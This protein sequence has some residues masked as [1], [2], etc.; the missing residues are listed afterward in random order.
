LLASYQ[1]TLAPTGHRT[2]I[3]EHSGR[4]VN[5][6]YD[7][8]YRLKEEAITQTD[9]NEISF[10]YQYDAIGNRVYSIEDGVHTKYTYDANDQL[11]KQGGV[12]YQYDKNGNTIR[13]A[14]E[15]NVLLYSYDF[16]NRL[17]KVI[18]EENGQVT[19]TVTYAYDADG[20]RVQTN[21][22]GQVTQYVVDSND[23]LSQVVAELDKDNQ[24]KVAY[25]YGDDLVSQ[26]RGNEIAYYHNKKGPGSNYI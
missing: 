18:T 1:Y 10:S 4:V 15:G 21:A 2:Q 25:L 14:E 6:S 26:Y 13:I 16:D 22:D 7:D 19:S 20:N 8:L 11:L 24:V 3:I 9:G 12:T 17:S 5:Y 23:S